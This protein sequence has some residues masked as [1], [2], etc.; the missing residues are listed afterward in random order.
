MEDPVGKVEGVG[1]V[2][3]CRQRVAF[4]NW[5]VVVNNYLLILN[6]FIELVNCMN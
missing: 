5:N 4:D 6:G 3:R 1:A 2:L